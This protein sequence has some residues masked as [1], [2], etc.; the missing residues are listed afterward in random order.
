MAP[1]NDSPK[2]RKDR[3]K[4]AYSRPRMTRHGKL[5]QTALARSY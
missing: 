3:K 2:S 1:R 4:K 5:A